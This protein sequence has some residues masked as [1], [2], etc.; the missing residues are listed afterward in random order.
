MKYWYIE[1]MGEYVAI[2]PPAGED[3]TEGARRIFGEFLTL[4]QPIL[5]QID[6]HLE[7]TISTL[8]PMFAE[9]YRPWQQALQQLLKNA[10]LVAKRI[11]LPSTNDLMEALSMFSFDGAIAFLRDIGISCKII[12]TDDWVK[13]F[14]QYIDLMLFSLT[15]LLKQQQTGLAR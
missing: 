2:I 15:I 1:Y 5:L 13:R 14:R 7:K 9:A 4:Y 3:D 12:I 11:P 10:H 6:N 8:D